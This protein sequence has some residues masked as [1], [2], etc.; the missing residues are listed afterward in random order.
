MAEGIVRIAVAQNLGRPA[1]DSLRAP[2][3]MQ[4]YNGAKFYF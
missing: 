4:R 3:R 2:R 1:P